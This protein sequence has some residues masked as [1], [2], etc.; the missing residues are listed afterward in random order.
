MSHASAE[1]PA[2]FGMMAEFESPEALVA[3]AR[4]AE[5]AGYTRYDAHTPFPIEDLED[6]V[7]RPGPY[8]GLLV[9]AGGLSGV[10]LGFLMEVYLAGEYYPV[11]IGGRPLLSWP[12]FIPVA[13][14]CG[15]LLAS[16]SAVFGMLALNGFPMPYHPVFNVERFEL[17]SQ[18]RFFLAIEAV[19][20][21]FDMVATSQFLQGLGA[22]AVME[23]P[24]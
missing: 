22:A 12:S 23:I 15:I 17:A 11:N 18:D 16:L 2:I 13:Y 20:P 7:P 9:L 4:G 24:H 19:D 5:K 21:K 8:V 6:A 10:L 3:A 1:R 14:E